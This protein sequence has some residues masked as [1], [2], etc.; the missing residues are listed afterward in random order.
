MELTAD[1]LRSQGKMVL[2]VA[3]GDSIRGLLALQ[4][5][6][7]DDAQET[8]DTLRTLG[9]KNITVLTGDHRL[10]SER[11]LSRL[12]GID[13]LHAEL[14]P[15]D[16][17]A[18]VRDLQAQGLRV[19]RGGA[20]ASTTRPPLSAR[21]IGI[22]MS[23]GADLAQVA[24]QGVILNDDLKSLCAA[25]RYRA[26]PAQGPGPLLQPGAG[27]QCFAG[28]AGGLRRTHPL[29]PRQCCTTPTTFGLMGYAALASGRES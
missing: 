29:L 17:A 4:G 8:L 18:I 26:T 20:T 9:I 19:G 27:R 12:R 22:C 15:E 2:Y 13:R 23:R 5:E 14:G 28:S 24:A 3:Q 21:D 11:L 1:L 10:S 6:L 16:K 7:R 25:L